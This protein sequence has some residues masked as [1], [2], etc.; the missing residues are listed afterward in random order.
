[1][2]I[3]FKN[4]YLK[5]RAIWPFIFPFLIL[6]SYLPVRN[7][8]SR[9]CIVLCVFIIVTGIISSLC[10][11]KAG[12]VFSIF[13]ALNFLIF[14][15]FSRNYN[16]QDLASE[17][18]RQLINY[19]QTSYV[20]GGENYTGIDCSGLVRIALSDAMLIQGLKSYNS[21]LVLK[22]FKLWFFDSSAKALL[23][24]HKNRTI[25]LF[26]HTSIKALD[27]HKIQSGDLALTS[28][29]LHVL[30]YLGDQ[31][32]IQADPTNMKVNINSKDDDNPWLQTPI[33][34]MRWSLLMQEDSN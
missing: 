21:Q 10:Q 19:Y 2:K 27:H 26:P 5:L 4:I 7:G 20:W 1:M 34:L 31:Q 6:L 11:N 16:R 25:H 32:W 17:Y 13:L 8:A 18:K 29:G 33:V 30:A 3:H 23:N 28:D 12:R 24:Q 22:A 14:I 9:I 15:I